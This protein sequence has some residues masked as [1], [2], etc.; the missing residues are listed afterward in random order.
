MLQMHC[1]FDNPSS[2][3]NDKGKEKTIIKVG[4][5]KIG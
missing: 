3:V 4:H 2:F 5:K 1:G